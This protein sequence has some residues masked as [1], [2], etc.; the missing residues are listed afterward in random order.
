MHLG[1]LVRDPNLLPALRE[2]ATVVDEADREARAEF[3]LRRGK[4]ELVANPDWVGSGA[5]EVADTAVGHLHD[6]LQ[7]DVDAAARKMATL[8]AAMADPAKTDLLP[9]DDANVDRRY[10]TAYKSVILLKAEQLRATAIVSAGWTT[11]A[12]DLTVSDADLHSLVSRRLIMTERMLWYVGPGGGHSWDF[13]PAHHKEWQDGWNRMFEY[14]RLGPDKAYNSLCKPA[15]GQTACDASGQMAGWERR[16]SGQFRHDIQLN[17]TASPDWVRHDDHE[18]FFKK[19][20]GTDPA[21]AILDIFTPSKRY[22]Q[23]NLLY[24]D[25]TL[26]CLHLEALV[27][28]KSK[29]D[30]N[31]TWLK[32]LTDVES[33]GWL[34]VINPGNYANGIA[35]LTSDR[36][37][38]HFT[39]GTIDRSELMVGDHVAVY[40]HPAYDMAMERVDV[41]RLEN[42]LVVST[43]PRLLLQ[44][45]GTNPLPFTSARRP[46]VKN[47]EDLEDS[48]RLNMLK[49][50]NRKLDVLRAAAVKEN[51]K[52]SPRAVID[53]FDSHA[54]VTL[55]TTLG[56][57]SK[58]DPADF[59]PAMA[60]LAR[61]W[62]RWPAPVD[63]HFHEKD[64]LADP[65]WAQQ[66]WDQQRVELE[67]ASGWFPLWLPRVDKVGA[68]VRKGGKISAVTRVIVSQPMAAGWNWYYDKDESLEEN[69]S[70]KLWV[71]RPR[72]T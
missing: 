50:F 3:L 35:F 20:G 11:L 47:K 64:I 4:A 52:A 60:K 18:L 63:Y 46:P 40:N 57:Y 71:L 28:V 2:G 70:H 41:W 13:A 27:R 54:K 67:G 42:A 62:I 55:R 29:R 38:R 45:H 32:G 6:R 34:R 61:W 22:D 68:P 37:P 10:R 43:Y 44:G 15:P 9:L 14:G 26:C 48:M 7:Q 30:G 24:C 12:G 56:P 19:A 66:I 25:Q 69:A 1:K 16:P 53:D 8:T 65:A 5:G 49:R 58:F 51:A 39:S 59:T 36:E 23:R 17:P 72:V 31:R 33:D 21:Q